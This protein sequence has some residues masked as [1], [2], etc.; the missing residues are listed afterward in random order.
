MKETNMEHYR[1][2]LEEI[3]KKNKHFGLDRMTGGAPA[4]CNDIGCG[5]CIFTIVCNGI[6]NA[7]EIERIKWLMSEYKPE[8]VL[9]AREKGFVEFAQEGWLARDMDGALCWFMRKPHR[10][11]DEGHRCWNGT[12]NT[13]AFKKLNE[14][15]PF[16]TWEDEEPWSISDLRKL[17]ALEYNPEDVAFKK[18]GEADELMELYD[19]LEDKGLVIPV[20]VVIQNIKDMPTAY[21]VKSVVERLEKLV[22]DEADLFATEEINYDSKGNLI[23]RSTTDLHSYALRCLDKAI[24]I[25]KSGCNV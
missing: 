17:K 11:K 12:A 5:D 16:I 3:S 7:V 19:G 18:G 2:T 10:C 1:K 15:F 13:I 20:D 6:D 14:I 8:P 21:D 4:A 25:V 22:T 23:I 9:T 24:E